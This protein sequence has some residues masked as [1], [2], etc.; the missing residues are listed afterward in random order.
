MNNKKCYVIFHKE[1]RSV[2]IE[3]YTLE[4]L[5]L[6]NNINIKEFISV[7]NSQVL[8]KSIIEKIELLNFKQVMSENLEQHIIL[9][10]RPNNKLD[11]KATLTKKNESIINSNK[12]ENEDKEQILQKTSDGTCIK[13]YLI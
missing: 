9:P 7:K 4:R 3:Y 8:T 1:N 12:K 10:R 11:I 13:C 6:L 5:C 2:L